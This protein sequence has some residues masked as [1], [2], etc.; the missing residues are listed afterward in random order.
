MWLKSLTVAV[1]SVG[2]LA[3]G[4]AADSKG[5]K[6]KDNGKGHKAEK[7]Q[8]ADKGCPPG[9]AKKGNGCTPP[10]LEKSGNKDV[11]QAAPVIVVTRDFVVGD[12][13]SD[14]Y[15][16]VLDPRVN[17]VPQNAISVRH[18]DYLYLIDR[19]SRVILDRLGHRDDW[20]WRWDDVDFADC[21]PGLAKKNPPCI[22][23]GQAKR[24]VGDDRFKVG[25]ALPGDHDLLFDPRLTADDAQSLY[26]R[27]GDTI[28]RIDR[29][30]GKVLD[31]IGAV[32]DLLP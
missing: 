9:L 25:D 7:S 14:D 8:K 6:G 28:Y 32:A 24:G 27:R 12:P 19:D 5:D 10:G 1:L 26:V 31:L 15:V 3:T 29:D 4:V 16:I 21:P 11:T 30:T 23:P 18:G 22:P 17:R 20:D 2:L 13:I